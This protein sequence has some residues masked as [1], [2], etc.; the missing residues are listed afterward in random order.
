MTQN[1]SNLFHCCHQSSISSPNSISY[2]VLVVSPIHGWSSL[3][4]NA[5]TEE[6]VSIVPGVVAAH[7]FTC[8]CIILWQ[9]CS[10]ESSE[11]WPMFSQRI[12]NH[13]QTTFI[14]SSGTGH[15]VRCGLLHL[16]YIKKMRKHIKTFGFSSK[17][18]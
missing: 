5:G 16:A 10:S 11:M 6:H 1:N 17:Q 13:R 3:D 15:T 9:G 8:C 7:R 18:K 2:S 14:R 4:A 12:R